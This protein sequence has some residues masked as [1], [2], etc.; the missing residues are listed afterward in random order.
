M[1]RMVDRSVSAAAFTDEAGAALPEHADVIVVGG[2]I[3]GAS[4][5]Y[6]LNLLGK[7][8]VLML[9]ANVLASGTTWHAA[10]LVNAGRGSAAMTELS[11]YGAQFYKELEEKSGIDVSFVEAGSLS[12]ARTPGRVDEILYAK[13]VADQCGVRNEYLSEERLREVWPIAETEG[14]LGALLMLDDGYMNPGWA[15]VA[16]AKLAHEA[17]TTV[18][19]QARATNLL[20]ENGRVTGVVT[21]RGAVTANTVVLACGLWT[22]DLADKVGVPVPLYPAEHVHVR[23]NEVEGAVPTLPVYRDLDN[24]YYLRH[25][26]GRLLVGAFEPDGLPRGTHEFSTEGFAEFPEDWAHFSKIR[27]QA[28]KTVPGLADAGYDRFLNAPESFTPDAEFILGETAEVEGLFVA[29][30]FNSQGIIYGPGVGKK[31]ADWIVSGSS[32]FASTSVDVRRFSKQQNNRHYLHARTVEALGRLYAMHWP[33]KQVDTARYVRR[34]PLYQ[35]LEEHGACFGEVN[36]LERAFWYGDPGSRPEYDYSYGRTSWFENVAAE[37]RATREGVT[38]FDLS[39]FAKF[40]VVGPDALAVCQRVATADIDVSVNKGVYTLFLNKNGTI[41]LDGTITRLAEDKFLVV[42]PSFT[43]HQTEAMLNKEAKGRAAAVFNATASLA[44]IAVNGPRSRELMQLVAPN[45]DWSNEAQPYTHGRMIEIADGYAYCLRVSF[46]GELGFE[47]YPSADLAINVLDALL[48]AG[49]PLGVKF[50]GYHALDSLRSEKG[51]RHHGH[52]IG[53]DVDP[54]SAGLGFTLAKDKPGGFIGLEAVRQLDPKSPRLRTVYVKL[55][56][57]EPL[58]VHD[59]T[60]YC[61]GKQ[62]GRLTSGAYGHTIGGAVGIALI[63]PNVDFEGVFE[64]KC[65]GVLYPATVQRRPFYDPKGERLK[66]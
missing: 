51:F 10:G 23:S 40:E 38:L 12:V 19:E 65:K 20:V 60:V 41:E 49:K 61:N 17:G 54:Y 29:A 57:P 25:E 28:E 50:A 24:S 15:S 53:P 45:E 34:T 11:K 58:F 27:T 22:R 7:T 39:P 56:D 62:V 31:L 35:R 42:T 59:E 52:D 63:D 32:D 18:R 16:I 1:E 46:V 3:V 43:Q 44:T 8:D 13:D 9:E 55:D 2:G 36:G 64:V 33:A 5:S 48:D 66:G 37:H 26:H 21:E 47:I 14:V 6:H 30:G 4:I